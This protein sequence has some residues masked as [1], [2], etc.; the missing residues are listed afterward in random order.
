MT[1]GQSSLTGRADFQHAYADLA[2]FPF[3]RDVPWPIR[4]QMRREAQPRGMH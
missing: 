4:T 3:A 1:E 2:R